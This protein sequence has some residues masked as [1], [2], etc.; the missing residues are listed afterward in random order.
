MRWRY[1]TLPVTVGRRFTS[2]QTFRGTSAASRSPSRCS[3]RCP[4][5]PRRRA[6]RA[7]IRVEIL[8]LTRIQRRP[9]ANFATQVRPALAPPALS[10][11]VT[12]PNARHTRQ[13]LLKAVAENHN[14]RLIYPWL[15]SLRAA[16]A[17]ADVAE[18]RTAARNI[19]GVRA[20]QRTI[21]FQAVQRSQQQ[22][23]PTSPHIC[24]VQSESVTGSTLKTPAHCAHSTGK[25]SSQ[26]TLCSRRS[27][28]CPPTPTTCAHGL[29]RRCCPAQA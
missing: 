4:N 19:Q 28:S 5:L 18:Q 6:R 13:A 7:L 10:Q 2:T 20:L 1:V 21:V 24:R 29:A 26:T 14:P 8:Q 27:S 25:P 12:H 9:E 22:P 23:H 15:V 3:C 16:T 17:A 11:R